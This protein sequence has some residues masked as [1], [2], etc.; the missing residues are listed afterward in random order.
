MFQI[1]CTYQPSADGPRFAPFNADSLHQ[2]DLRVTFRP[3]AW[4]PA[5]PDTGQG[6]DFDASI[7]A[8]EMMDWHGRDQSPKQLADAALDAAKAFLEAHHHDAMWAAAEQVTADHFGA[9]D[10]RRAA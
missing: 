7:E 3:I 2:C 4:Y 5:E 6:A 8:I 1:A 10:F 9:T